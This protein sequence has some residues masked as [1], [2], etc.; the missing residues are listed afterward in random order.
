[1]GG[2]IVFL[3]ASLW[4][5]NSLISRVEC[6]YQTVNISDSKKKTRRLSPIGENFGS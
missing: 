5:F 6:Y 3:N 1:M 4:L 2:K